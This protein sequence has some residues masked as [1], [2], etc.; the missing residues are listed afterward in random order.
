MLETTKNYV[1]EIKTIKEKVLETSAESMLMYG[2]GAELELVQSS[3]KAIDLACEMAEK[4]A[5]SITEINKKLDELL[6]LAK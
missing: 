3:L 2:S 5:E 1:K 4:Y 6:K